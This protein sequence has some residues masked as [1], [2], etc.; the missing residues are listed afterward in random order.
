LGWLDLACDNGF[1]HCRAEGRTVAAPLQFNVLGPLEVVGEAGPLELGAPK[2]RALL[3]L[4]LL[5]PG[6]VVSVD[7]LIEQLWTG[8]PPSGAQSTL[9]AYVSNVRRLLEPDRRPGTPAAVLVTRPPGYALDVA[10]EQVDAV[11]FERAVRAAIAAHTERRLEE[12]ASGLAGALALWRG[13]PY[14]DVA[15]EPWAQTECERLAELQLVALETQ[16]AVD[17]DLGRH[18]SVVVEAERLC[19]EHPVRERLRELLM[20]AL[21][22]SGRQAEA[23]RAYQDARD[24]LVEELGIEPGPALRALEDRILAQDPALDWQGPP[25]TAAPAAPAATTATAGPGEPPGRAP[26]VGRTLERVRL[27]ARL[28]DVRIGAARLVL[29]SGEPGI[30]KTRLAE[31]LSAAARG[32]G[33][34]VVWA[35]GWE[36]DGAPAF[37]PWVQVLR[38]IAE[39]VPRDVL[40]AALDSEGA[41]IARVVPDYAR[42]ATV[43]DD[44]PDAETARFRFFEAVTSLLRRLGTSRP[45]VVVLDDIHWADQSSLRLLE[46][47]VESLRDAHVMLVATYRDSEARAAPLAPALARL[48]RT[49]ELERLALTGLSPDEVGSYVASVLGDE[50]APALA[51]TLHD[52]TAGNPFF[53]AELVRLLRHEGRI[54]QGDVG[55]QVPEGVRDVVRTRL[56]RLP[57]EAIPVLTAGAIAGREFDV[58]LVAHVCDLDEDRALDLVEAAWMV[59]IVDESPD[60]Y[61]HFRFSHEIVRDT[62]AEELSGTRRI[63]L[64]KRIGEAIEELHGERNPGFLTACAHHFAEAASLGDPLKAVL[65]GQRAADRLV[66][67]FAYEDALPVYER[68]IDIYEQYDVGTYHTRADLLIGLGW[69]LRASGR[70]ADAR[71]A[72]RRAI[73]VAEEHGDEVRIARAVLG[74]GGGSFWGW[75]DEF[76]VADEDL[77]G[78]LERALAA[79]GDEDSVLRCE[80]L[81]RL[82][83]ESYFITDDATRERL[84]A[85]ALAMARRLDDPV[86]L[87]AALAARHLATWSIANL[88]E[89]LALAD[90]LVE[91]AQKEGLYYAELIGRHFRMTDHVEAGDGT[92]FDEDFAVCERLAERVGQHAFRVQLAWFRATR[93]LL[94]APLDEAE[95]LV[96][97]A[98]RLNLTSNDSAA[99]M[100]FGVQLLQLR[101]D[102]GRLAELE[103]LVREAI[104]TQPHV[105]SAW[106][107]ALAEIVATEGRADEARDLV[108]DLLVEGL[109]ALR[110]EL[111]APTYVFRMGDVCAMTG[112]RE[113]AS[114]LLPL[115]DRFSGPVAALPTGHLCFGAV[116]RVRGQLLRTLG[117]PD[118]AIAAFRRAIEVETA[119]GA[120]RHANRSRVGLA[121]AL[122]ERG[123]AAEAAAVAAEALEV[124]ERTGTPALAAQA[125]EL[126]DAARA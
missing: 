109:P 111:L 91:A 9:Q 22:R 24:V 23:L 116:D 119:L 103:P 62:L 52:R 83:V 41:D 4:L 101:R 20:L 70:L 51:G 67:Q 5:E 32:L 71:E 33:L 72:L 76:G 40:A 90:E 29:V 55:S 73:D 57:E 99:W 77:V 98:F 80:L 125:R 19:K 94:E 96:E 121:R 21:Y 14:A 8:Q 112:H 34:H 75:W 12:A 27:M 97:E 68:A 26:F 36:G 84:T 63:R 56:A 7:R 69:A 10:P 65:Y 92:A 54:A 39:D 100:A 28:D 86:A 30:G 2:H 117:R 123:D 85:D 43:V 81:S 126:R 124:A 49:P 114:L 93:A 11:R 31:E 6:R 108:A 37:W 95:R 74:I 87:C 58:G 89:R 102:Q 82:A 79:L 53:V 115:L 107:I 44:A 17:L 35:R 50:A 48:A 42:F 64:H 106:R 66:A 118:E 46:F 16:L 15:F 13:Q 3:A 120:P 110:I 25:A 104:D 1:P 45:L 113:G 38:T 61:G 60:A 78:Y 122:L 59:G 18:S 47:A 88:P 105:G